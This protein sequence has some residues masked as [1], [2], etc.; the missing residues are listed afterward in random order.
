MK[1]AWRYAT[2]PYVRYHNI[3][4]RF[5]L[6]DMASSLPVELY[7]LIRDGDRLRSKVSYR[8]N[9]VVTSQRFSGQ[10]LFV[11]DNFLEI[12]DYFEALYDIV[13]LRAGDDDDN[14]R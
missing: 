13:S 2:I 9:V 11:A 10:R 7:I 6:P 8:Q 3:R 12:S 5:E 4:E 14:N 1:P